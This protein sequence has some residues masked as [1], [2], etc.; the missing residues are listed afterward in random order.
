MLLKSNLPLLNFRF[1][2]FCFPEVCLRDFVSRCSCSG[3]VNYGEETTGDGFDDDE[4]PSEFLNRLMSKSRFQVLQ[5][6]LNFR[7]T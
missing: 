5:G 4:S 2:K 1:G 6:I 7:D 3:L